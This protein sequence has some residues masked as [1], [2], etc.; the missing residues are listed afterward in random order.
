MRFSRL[1]LA[2]LACAAAITAPAC[3]QERREIPAFRA[4][5]APASPEAGA[6]VE[7]LMDAYFTAWA[8]ED[9]AA[10]AA[11][12]AEDAEWINAY[13]RIFQSA[14]TLGVFMTE[15]M[16]PGFDPS[17]TAAEIAAMRQVSV[18]RLGDDVA[19]LHY[20]TDSPRGPSRAD[21]E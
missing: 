10:L 21:A 14:A 18:R 16:F 11:L 19:V 6:E 7:A 5:N 17:V 2:A 20:V 9:G 8:R 15:R 12:F 3:A 4:Y 1:S 13:A